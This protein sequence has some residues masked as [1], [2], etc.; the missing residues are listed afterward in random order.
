MKSSRYWTVIVLLLLAVTALY[1]RG[2]KDLV[3]PS[4][5]LDQFPRAI[6][7]WTGTDI[8]MDQETLD[9]LG[10]GFF[11]NRVYNPTANPGGVSAKAERAPV[12]LFIGYFPTQRTGQS[13]HSPQ[14]CLPGAGWTFES[15]GVTDITDA[16]GK[17][18]V[19]GDY[20]I[21]KDT[22]K[23]EV[24]YWYQAHGRAIANDYTAKFY[25]VADSIR[26]RRSDAALVRV[27]VPL[28]PGENRE[29]AHRRAIRFTEQLIP[30]LPAYIPN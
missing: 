30:L 18:S 20:I 10:Q 25:M 22:S 4:L 17:T 27:V 21:T 6:G 12:G 9:V 19:V 7:A 3:P 14:H 11:L 28:S 23:A 29:E 15:S 24:L 16:T 2:D 13:I 26:Y 1:R 8:P 5:P